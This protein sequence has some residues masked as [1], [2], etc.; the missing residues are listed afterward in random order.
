MPMWGLA[1]G[2]SLLVGSLLSL[3]CATAAC[4]EECETDDDCESDLA[5]FNGL[6]GHVCLP[7]E[8]NDCAN[9]CKYAKAESSDGDVACSYQTCY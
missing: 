7:Q 3:G 8:C 6:T 4:Q 1:G 2:A 9:G 5:C